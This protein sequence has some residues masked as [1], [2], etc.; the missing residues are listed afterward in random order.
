[1][2]LQAQPLAYLPKGFPRNQSQWRQVFSRV[3]PA[4][5]V[6]VS[7]SDEQKITA[8]S[9]YAD[10]ISW[11][12]LLGPEA[13]MT[14]AMNEEDYAQLK[15]TRA[16]KSAVDSERGNA[17]IPAPIG[18]HNTPPQSLDTNLHPLPQP[19]IN[20]ST[21]PNP[22]SHPPT[23][24]FP[25]IHHWPPALLALLDPHTLPS[26]SIGQIQHL[27]RR[28]AH[29]FRHRPA[30][31]TR[32]DEYAAG[33]KAKMLALAT[34]DAVVFLVGDM[35][36]EAELLGDGSVLWDIW[37]GDGEGVGVDS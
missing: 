35:F 37:D 25:T 26:Q 12:E 34:F 7:M 23:D 36:G 13:C 8:V 33:R 19:S 27:G 9:A 15:L 2:L 18:E 5:R 4:P 17:D 1:M 11:T 14:M 29:A 10:V 20:P 6:L 28:A 21:P 31:F 22:P 24:P 30:G 3:P 16:N 32:L